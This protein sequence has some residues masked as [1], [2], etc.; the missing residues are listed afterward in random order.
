MDKNIERISLLG[1]CAGYQAYLSSGADIFG[2]C[3]PPFNE[4]FVLSFSLALREV[5][6]S[7]HRAVRVV[8]CVPHW[9]SQAFSGT[10]T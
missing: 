4:S 6:V 5:C 2:F 8:V 1:L 3:N 7:L 10:S 9:L